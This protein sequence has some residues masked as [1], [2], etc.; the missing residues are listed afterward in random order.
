MRVA[1][2]T[3]TYRRPDG[4]RRLLKSLEALTFRDD[5]PELEIV[6][7][8]NDADESAR[9]VCDALREASTWPIRYEVEPHRGISFAR[10]KSVACAVEHADFAAF[11]DDDEV[12]EPEWLDELLRVQRDTGA[13]I[14]TGPVEP[15]FPEPVARW[16]V[17]GRFFESRRHR[18]GEPV[19]V[20]YTHNVLVASE[21]FR[22]F[23]KHFGDE[24]SMTGGS[25]SEFFRRVR[26]AG[27]SIVWADGALV[28]EWIPKSRACTSWL[29]R[30][31][32]RTGITLTVIAMNQTPSWSTRLLSV[33]KAGV[34]LAIGV[35]TCVL[36]LVS[37]RAVLVKGLRF[38]AYAFG[39]LVSMFGARFEEYRTVHGT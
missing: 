5:P 26:R 28:R 24:F 20:A 23:D 16:I 31:S 25:D 29:V 9:A 8:D 21:V 30:R 22:A 4:L 7:V 13:D 3:I 2:C 36:G 14:V 11:I 27:R 18:T 39:T 1:I 10:N 35:A 37:G 15:F 19:D 6:V 38:L 33:A 34:W 12:A 32:Y 17:R